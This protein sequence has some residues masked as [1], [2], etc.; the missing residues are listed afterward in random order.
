MLPSCLIQLASALIER[1]NGDG[2]AGADGLP[3]SACRVIL[4]DGSP[5][6]LIEGLPASERDDRTADADGLPASAWSESIVDSRLESL[7]GAPVSLRALSCDLNSSQM[8]ASPS[9]SLCVA[10]WVPC[11]GSRLPRAS[12]A[13]PVLSRGVVVGEGSL[14][15]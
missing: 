7:S 4:V 3:A 12:D 5:G 8:S 9:L 6:A 13:T 10:G 14:L 1:R 15:P 11:G 2:R